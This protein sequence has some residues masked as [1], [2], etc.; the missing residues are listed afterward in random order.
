MSAPSGQIPDQWYQGL[1]SFNDTFWE[2]NTDTG[3]ITFLADPKGE[4]GKE[5]DVIQPVISV[6]EGYFIFTNKKDGTLWSL[7]VPK[8][9][10]P[11]EPETL[12]ST[13]SPAELQDAKGSLPGSLPT[14]TKKP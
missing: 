13:L 1:L 8:K 10:A 2:V 3:E 9:I 6:N 11:I 7:R 12:P 14:T 5:F 4:T